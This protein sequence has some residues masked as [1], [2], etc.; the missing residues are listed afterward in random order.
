MA[1][2]IFLTVIQEK[3]VSAIIDMHPMLKSY[4]HA[5]NQVFDDTGHFWQCVLTTQGT[6]NA[7]VY[8]RAGGNMIKDWPQRHRMTWF[9]EY[10]L[11][12]NTDNKPLFE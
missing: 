7:Q 9:L 12:R 11:D 2:P 1:N 6:F 10:P 8:H 5:E 4:I 3:D